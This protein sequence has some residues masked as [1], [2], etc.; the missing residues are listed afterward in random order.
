MSSV[1]VVEDDR[2]V[3]ELILEALVDEHHDV[4][5]AHDDRSAYAQLE[6]EPRTFQVL[7]ADIDLGEG[8]TGFDVARRARLLN[9][10]L[11]VIYISGGATHAD[12]FGVEGAVVVPKPFSPA[13][14]TDA[15]AA[16]AG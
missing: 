13:E 7:V 1:L 12:R 9:P 16:K 11:Q 2:A 4:A 5:L 8:T 3:A 15:V 14:L 10:D 6:Q